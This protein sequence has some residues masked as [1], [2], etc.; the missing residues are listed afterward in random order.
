MR[1]YEIR[2]WRKRYL[3]GGKL[4]QLLFGEVID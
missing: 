2:L 4:E 3:E 1:L